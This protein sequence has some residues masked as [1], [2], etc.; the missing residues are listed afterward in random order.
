MQKNFIFTFNLQQLTLLFLFVIAHFN[1]I[2]LYS[3]EKEIEND[4]Q[5]GIDNFIENT[6]T[7]IHN[8]KQNKILF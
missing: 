7:K 6:P 2:N 1:I 5:L 8:L 4:F 3:T